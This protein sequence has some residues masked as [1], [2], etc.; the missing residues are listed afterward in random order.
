MSPSFRRAS[1]IGL[2]AAIGLGLVTAILPA[3]MT[4]ASARP[5]TRPAT[6]SNLTVSVTGPASAYRLDAAWTAAANATSYRVVVTNTLGTV[7]DNGSVVDTSYTGTVTQPVNTTIKVSVTA[8]SGRRHGKSTTKAV[9]LPDLTAPT[10]SYSLTPTDSSDGNITIQQTSLTDDLSIA[11]AVTQHVD[12]GDGTWSDVAGTVTSIPHGYGS[13]KAVYYPVVTVG[14]EAGNTSSYPLTAVV[15]D[16]TAPTGTFSA[17]PAS[18]WAKWTVVTVSQSALSDDLSTAD[19]I[20]R[21]VDWGDGSSDAWT[22]GD[23]LTHV[24]TTAGAHTP[25]VTIADEAGNTAVLATSAVDVAVDSVAPAT[26]LIAPTAKRLSVR[27]WST[28]RGRANDAGTGVRVVRVRAI[29]KRGAVWYAYRPAAKVWVRAGKRPA[30]A[31]RT[32][33]VARVTTDASHR[34]SL[35]LSHLTRG[36][37]VTKVSAIDNVGNASVWK[38]RTIQLA[39]R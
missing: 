18:A 12:W 1:G 39:R 25:S 3:A 11:A 29:E 10:A 16:V 7:L 32:S 19:K 27:S 6:V 20:S 24:Y 26:R 38:A 30:S 33:R 2:T 34:W 36:T 8:Y 17:S 31:W 15:A 22:T 35:R 13:M 23:S 14:D 4:T 21:L 9:I 28:L 5:P 37:L